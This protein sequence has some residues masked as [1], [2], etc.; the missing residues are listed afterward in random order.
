MDPL[1]ASLQR[2]L[3]LHQ[4]GEFAA[5]MPL[6]RE[7]LAAQP[8]NADALHLLGVALRQAG[9]AAAAAASIA[10][11]IALDPSLAVA[12]SNLGAA[13]QDL[14]RT[15]EALAAYD[16]ALALKPDYAMAHANRGNALRRLGRMADALDSYD[17]ALHLNPSAAEAWSNRGLALDALGRFEAAM[18]SFGRALALR[19]KFADAWSGQG[20][21][22]QGAGHL[23]AA[24]DSYARALECDPAHA[25][26][27]VNMATLLQRLHR[28]DDALAYADEAVA[29]HPANPAALLRRANALHAL[30]R[31]EEAAHAF[32]AARASGADPGLCSFMLAALGAGPA[33]AAAPAPY[34]QALFDQYAG[35]FD[36]HL[37]QVLGYRTPEALAAA[38]TA[39]VQ[40]KGDVL[41]AGCGTGLCGPLLRPF[42]ATLT[43]V[44]LSPK[45]V[46]AARRTGVY[47]RLECE[48][49]GAFL[50]R[51]RQAFDIVAAADV[52][53]Y[54]G[55]LE[56]VFA[57]AAG[58]LR[59]D[60]LLAFSVE[61]GTD[62]GY[63]LQPSGRYA[64]GAGYLRALAARHGVEV[65]DLSRHTLRRDREGAIEGYLAVMRL[66]RRP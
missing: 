9:D 24:G 43:G 29:R 59:G 7:V 17:R 31:Q 41:D 21:A 27:L 40:A 61:A 49:L 6:Y 8:R 26:A 18:D 32:L 25:E 4:R 52:L 48:E 58:A 3:A 42:A 37:G 2:A 46:E 62:A 66:G 44:D 53:V 64:H 65:L 56:P 63:A 16:R 38:L 34:V 45:M 22:L 54:M 23:E 10:A 15:E 11:A 1:A 50:A 39:H 14:G 55:D 28:H 30:G 33:P 20:V 57:S 12:H 51:H 60:G 47:D 13:L 35:H 5:A 36:E 19:P